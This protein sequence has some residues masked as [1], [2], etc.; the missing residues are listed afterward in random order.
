MSIIDKVEERK[1]QILNSS[2][3]GDKTKPLC[4]ESA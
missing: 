4:T 2:A 1:T 3:E